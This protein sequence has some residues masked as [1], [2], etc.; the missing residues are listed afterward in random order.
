MNWRLNN[1]V[2]ELRDEADR[3]LDT[4]HFDRLSA[5]YA[6]SRGVLVGR[7]WEDAKAACEKRAAKVMVQHA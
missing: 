6:D 2:W 5:Q 1:H 3:V 7:R 4:L